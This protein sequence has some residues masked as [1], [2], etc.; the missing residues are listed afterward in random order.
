MRAQD[1]FHPRHLIS[2]R[3]HMTWTQK[4]L[5]VRPQITMIKRTDVHMHVPVSKTIKIVWLAITCAW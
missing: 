3:H 1:F 5:P 2:G 4:S